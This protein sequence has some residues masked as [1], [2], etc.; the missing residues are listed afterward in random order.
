MNKER[1][2]PLKP[3]R[4][5]VSPSL[6]AEGMNASH[7]NARRLLNDAEILLRAGS[8][9][10]A[11]ALAVLSIEESG[12]IPLLRRLITAATE[13]ERSAIWKE[14]QNHRTKGAHWIVP[15]LVA[16]GATRLRDL[17]EA[18]RPG[19]EHTAILNAVK[20]LGLYLD[21]YGDGRW[22]EPGDAIDSSLAEGIVETAKFLCSGSLTR[23]PFTAREV[24]LWQEHLGPKGDAADGDYRNLL[25]WAAAM[26]SEGLSS[27]PAAAFEDFVKGMK[28][29]GDGDEGGH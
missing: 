1:P 7:R 27:Y 10:S 18:E 6:I 21:C 19:A 26:D 15:R 2:R 3:Y 12:K 11:A 17:A 28:P 20:Q 4:G 5:T 9:A 14:F 13:K 22:S 8:Y 29:G 25:A 16:E 23:K 24:E